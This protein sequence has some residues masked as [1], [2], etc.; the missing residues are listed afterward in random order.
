M[1]EQKIEAVLVETI[2]FH[3]NEIIL[4]E[5]LAQPHTQIDPYS[6]GN[7]TIGRRP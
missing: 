3:K 2:S 6:Y 4:N 5:L 7:G 1:I